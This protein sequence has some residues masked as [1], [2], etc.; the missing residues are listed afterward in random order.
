MWVL[1]DDTATLITPLGIRAGI[2]QES[3]PVV[4]AARQRKPIQA[5]CPWPLAR[6]GRTLLGCAALTFLGARCAVAAPFAEFRESEAQPWP[7]PSV[8]DGLVSLKERLRSAGPCFAEAK[9]VISARDATCGDPCVILRLTVQLANC[10]LASMAMQPIDCAPSLTGDCE[11]LESGCL[12]P[13]PDG[14]LTSSVGR[15]GSKGTGPQSA[16]ALPWSSRMFNVPTVQSA[17][18]RPTLP[19]TPKRSLAM[20]PCWP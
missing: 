17:S 20:P 14:V 11:R 13:M 3:T 18:V 4:P 9:E 15:Y 7:A 8:A 19:V 12:S 5:G 1:V 6:A 10:L 2:M 16:L